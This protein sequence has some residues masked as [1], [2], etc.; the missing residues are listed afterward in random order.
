MW[1]ALETCPVSQVPA[2]LY[3]SNKKLGRD[4]EWSYKQARPNQPQRG[5]LSVS[6]T[7]LVM[8]SRFPWATLRLP[9]RPSDRLWWHGFELHVSRRV[10]WTGRLSRYR[11]YLM[12]LLNF[13]SWLPTLRPLVLISKHN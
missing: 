12:T 1:L 3:C 9:C 13:S 2:S 6:R 4:W 11:T 8:V 10:K 7:G 5:L